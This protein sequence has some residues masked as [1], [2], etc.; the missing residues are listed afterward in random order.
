MRQI[1]L[2]EEN[3][4]IKK[5]DKPDELKWRQNNKITD[6]GSSSISLSL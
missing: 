5:K 2:T 3:V 1:Y 6:K 4:C